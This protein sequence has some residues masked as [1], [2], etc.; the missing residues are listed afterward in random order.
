[1][2]GKQEPLGDFI[3]KR[4]RDVRSGVVDELRAN[5][6]RMVEAGTVEQFIRRTCAARKF[7]DSRL[8]EWPTLLGGTVTPFS[9]FRAAFLEEVTLRL[10]GFAAAGSRHAKHLQVV[11]LATGEG[12]VTGVSL[13]FRRDNLPPTVPVV[14]RRDREDVVVGFRRV[15]RIE[16]P[17]GTSCEFP[18][19]L[20]PACVIACKI[21]VDATRLE[22][23]LA[24]VK[25]ISAPYAKC[26]FMVVAEWDAL[27]DDWHD[28]NRLVLDSLYSPVESMLF[29]RGESTRRPPNP[30]LQAASLKHPYIPAQLRAVV[31]FVEE[32]IDGWQ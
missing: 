18:D 30:K 6:R 12:L 4:L 9:T 10:A 14:L 7:I 1:M 16:G 28:E 8:D 23:V 2:T 29:L 20:I 25:N 21:Y 19:E 11:K 24:K 3:G 22:N 27:G 13:A 31:K 17:N 15:L 5:Y 32:A 26:R